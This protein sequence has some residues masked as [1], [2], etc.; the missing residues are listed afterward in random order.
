MSRNDL[1]LSLCLVQASLSP[2]HYRHGSIIVRGGK[3]IGKG[4]NDYRSGY[5]GGVLSTGKL[6]T[7]SATNGPA[8]CALKNHSK[9]RM[10]QNQS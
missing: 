4:F 6:S 10:K 5:N 7:V 2:L 9:G 3:V 8:I 1:Y